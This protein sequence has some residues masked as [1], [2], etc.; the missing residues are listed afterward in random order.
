MNLAAPPSQSAL[1]ILLEARAILE[2]RRT[3]SQATQPSTLAQ[4]PHECSTL[5]I[6]NV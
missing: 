2:T 4:S 3:K 5:I 1:E 6:R